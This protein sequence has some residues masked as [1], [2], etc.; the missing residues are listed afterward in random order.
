[1]E[2]ADLHL[3]TIHSDGT[4]TPEEVVRQAKNCGLK[5]ISITDHDAVSG[6]DPA[7]AAGHESGIEVIPGVELS[8]THR[9]KDIH[10]L[11][12]FIDYTDRR[13]LSRLDAFRTERMRRVER[14]VAKLSE[15]GLPIKAEAVLAKAGSGAVGR[16]HVA[17]VLVEEG[18]VASYEEAFQKYLGDQG[19][20]H[21]EKYRMSPEEGIALI[22]SVGGVS[23]LAHP[24]CY[25]EDEIIQELVKNGLDGIETT[26]SESLWEDAQHYQKIA[27]KYH[28][29]ESGGSDYHGER[30][31]GAA[32]GTR[33][34]PYSFVE[35]L[36]D[37][38]VTRR[39]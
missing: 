9:G 29:L 34:I 16:P 3:H 38:S 2:F 4:S 24:G 22:R 11:G 26:Q 27:Q 8:V 10:L 36:R 15:I 30:G 32:I 28:L 35:K 25:N 7:I 12:Y 33:S 37:L 18:Y 39:S 20:V 6:I 5:A 23:V 21:A 31:S 17:R 1:M 13:F 14:M 19:P